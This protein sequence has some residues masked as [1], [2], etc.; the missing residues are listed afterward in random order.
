MSQADVLR[1]RREKVAGLVD[2]TALELA[3][4]AQIKVG[5]CYARS[6]DPEQAAQAYR[7]VITA[8]SQE[9]SLASEAHIRL[10]DMYIESGDPAAAERTYR[11]A[12][13]GSRDRIFQGAMQSLL[14]EHF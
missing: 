6:G 10:A 8:F 9:R 14:A 4:K 3:A 11:E 13:D 1:M 2:E 7:R 12:I 5:D